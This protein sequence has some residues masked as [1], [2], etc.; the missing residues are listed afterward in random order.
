METPFICDN[1]NDDSCDTLF[2]VW[3]RTT[4][5][6]NPFAKGTVSADILQLRRLCIGCVTRFDK[7]ELLQKETTKQLEQFK[8]LNESKETLCSDEL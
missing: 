3:A 5:S 2:E 1:C 8:K 7:L 4:A 6:L